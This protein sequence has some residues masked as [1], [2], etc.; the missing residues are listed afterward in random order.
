MKNKIVL[1][2]GSGFIGAFLAKKFH[3]LGHKVF[4]LTRGKT[5]E[6]ES[7]VYLNWD[8]KTQGD[9]AQVLEG[10]ELVINLA[11]KSVDCRYNEKNKKTILDSR[12]DATHALRKA[13]Q[14]CK[15]PPEVWINSSTATIYRHAEDRPMD[16]F[17]GEIGSGFSVEVAKAWEKAFFDSQTPQTRKIAFRSAIVLGSGGGVL[18]PFKNLV[19]FGLGGVQGNGRQ[20]FSWIHEEDLFEIIRFIQANG[21]EG[22]VNASAPSPVPN[23]EVMKSFRKIL[24]MPLGL[25]APSFLLVVGAWFLR[26]ETELL[27]KSRWVVPGR[28]LKEGYH[29]KF[30]TLPEALQTL[31]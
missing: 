10:A 1:A 26:T 22:V 16:E 30:P 17:T 31:L 14:Q 20:M 5:Q 25:P 29:F 13:I 24:Q 18:V 9:W 12:V 7:A 8:G 2:G 15:V 28:L 4:I 23:R 19:N 3:D 27:L 21:L 11:G 6:N